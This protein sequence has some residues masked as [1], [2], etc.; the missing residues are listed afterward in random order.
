MNEIKT[1]DSSVESG[2]VF[3]DTKQGVTKMRDALLAC[4][5]KHLGVK[6]YTASYSIENISSA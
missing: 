3:S 5:R 2:T 4:S 6:C 1:F